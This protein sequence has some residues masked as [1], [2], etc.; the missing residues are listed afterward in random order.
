MP[1]RGARMAERFPA[2]N[3]AEILSYPG[4]EISLCAHIAVTSTDP[5]RLTELRALP[6]WNEQRKHD[7][8]HG[9]AVSVAEAVSRCLKFAPSPLRS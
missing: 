4:D 1:E 7:C 2:K 8:H 3:W 6:G 9:V 5:A